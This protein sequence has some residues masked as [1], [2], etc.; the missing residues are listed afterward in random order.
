MAV[1]AEQWPT[2]LELVN[3]VSAGEKAKTAEEIA[4][5]AQALRDLTNG[6][7]VGG[8]AK[9]L[10]ADP[11]GGLPDP[12]R[13]AEARRAAYGRNAFARKTLT[14]YWKLVCEA[15]ND[16][17]LKMLLA[18]AT[19]ELIC[20]I[21]WS[22]DQQETEFIEPVAMYC[23]V[24]IIVNVQSFLDWQRERSFDALSKQLATS[25]QRFL[26]RGGKEIQVT[27]EEIV[28]G[29]IL[30]FNSHMAAT[31]SCDGLLLKGEGVKIDE[32]ALTGEPDP[33]EK[34]VG[35]SPFLISGTS[36]NAGAGTMLVVA[37]GEY[38]VSG[39]IKKAVYDSG[40]DID[41]DDGG[42][43]SPLN[44]KLE[45]L[46]SQ[47]GYVGEFVAVLCFLAQVVTG[48]L[49]KT[50]SQDFT[51]LIDYFVQS[52][53]ILACAIPEGL[54]LSLTIALAFSSRE[55]A[56]EN[57]L[58][59]TLE[60]CETMGSATTICTD[61]TGTLTANRMTVRCAYLA[62]K[63]Y[64][65]EGTEPLGPR[66]KATPK[67]KDVNRLVGN[68]AAICSMDESQVIF[69]D[70]K[71]KF[72]GNPTDCALLALA[73]DLGVSYEEVRNS[74]P[75]R[76]TNTESQGF[77]N[78]FSSARKMMSWAV[79]IQAGT[80]SPVSG[81]THRLYVKGASEI[82]LSRAT[83]A[84]Q[85]DGKI[86]PLSDQSKK[87]V[88]TEAISTFAAQAMRTIGLAYK[89][90]KRLPAGELHPSVLN[91]DGYPA[92]LC[93]TGLT[94]IGVVGIEDPLRPEV[95][96]AIQRCYT[97][98]ID[99][100]MV[101]GDNL[102]TAVAIAKGA[103]ILDKQ[104]H[105][106]S[107]GNVL[108]MCAMDAKTF[109][110]KVHTYSREGEAI[111]H[112]DK[113][114]E[115]WPFL[116]VLARSSPEDK[117]TLARGLNASKLYQNKQKVKE[118]KNRGINVFPDQQI[119]AMTGDGTNDAPALKFA[120]VGFAMG[121]SGT[122][123]AKDA[124][125]IILLDDNFA[126][127]VTAAKWG[128]NVVDSI[129]KF[130]QFQLTVNAGILAI[131]IVTCF[132]PGVV[133][134]GK[135]VALDPPITVLQMLWINLLMDALGAMALGS[136]MPCD[137]Q[138]ERPPVNRSDSVITWRMLVNMIGQA[139]YQV[140][141]V[142]T[143]L[144]IPSVLGLEE[145]G[146]HTAQ[147]SIIF[148]TFVLM[149]IVNEFN[150]RTLEGQFNIFAGILKNKTFLFITS[151]TAAIQIC[152]VQFLGAPLEIARHGLTRD[153][154]LVCIGCSLG[155]L[156]WQ[157]LMNLSIVAAKFSGSHRMRRNTTFNKIMN[158]RHV[159][160]SKDLAYKGQLNEKLLP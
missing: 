89:D 149:T 158:S 159:D 102:S 138:L 63:I 30:S 60:S 59:K 72:L 84:L 50:W 56:H 115:I 142:L 11:S 94:L 130:V 129:Q 105:Y 150:C 90:L 69:E 112:Q 136:E 154:W 45:T 14:P 36:V 73:H 16:T 134:D 29:D 139:L 157:Q 119:V 97:A 39:K 113:F 22:K 21:V 34:Q 52:L 57:N 114:D 18:M 132:H 27:D 35:K 86:T 75:G 148:N 67:A 49:N 126:T 40:N 12:V 118:F 99:V 101:T 23:S 2:R 108:P 4:E 7:G 141:V 79:P 25:N 32:S 61:K 116:R 80:R 28:V 131:N 120:D 44:H 81:S 46:A 48:Y 103:R 104:L 128:R 64:A 70:S 140:T 137:E 106:D 58:V 155:C 1:P 6:E 98:G 33:V 156:V 107:S 127:I 135:V 111:F 87:Q 53:G 85:M 26:L 146:R 122:Q 151:V 66:L 144:F 37:V 51:L 10:G 38:S 74:T 121:I 100:R 42:H 91:A 82:I 95:G 153:Q 77:L 152:M 109:R 9:R 5:A 96:P 43:G 54:P 62:G 123:I 125:N 147:Y 65:P 160:A 8:L 76:A 133:V 15:L 31:I 88:E 3:L 110:Q 93:E 17:I 68:L 19:L 92:L 83:D 145:T 41:H 20:K 78:G 117:L 55:M 47:V 143:F 13:D 24:I 124:A 71:P